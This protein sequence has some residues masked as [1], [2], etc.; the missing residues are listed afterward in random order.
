MRRRKKTPD[1]DGPISS[2][3]IQTSTQPI[4]SK[5]IGEKCTAVKYENRVTEPRILSCAILSV[6]IQERTRGA[7]MVCVYKQSLEQSK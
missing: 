6:S 4:V 5:K 7:R 1:N 2:Y 3:Q